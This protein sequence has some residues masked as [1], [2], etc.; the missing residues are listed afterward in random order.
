MPMQLTVTRNRKTSKHYNSEGHGISLTIE[1]DQG[2][3]NRPGE[4]QARISELYREADAALDQQVGAPA[5]P[6]PAHQQRRTDRYPGN[7]EWNGHD[8]RPSQSNGHSVAG[9]TAAQRRAI[10]AIANQLDID[11]NAECQ[12]MLGLELERLSVKDASAFI[13][14][15]KTNEQAARQNGNGR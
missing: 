8:R 7:G 5:S 15:L 11:P 13:D 1:L 2:L 9:M 4:L 12:A 14:H 10:D 3:L 6:P